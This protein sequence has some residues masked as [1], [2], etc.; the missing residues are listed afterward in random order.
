M[1]RVRRSRSLWV[2]VEVDSGIPVA[3]ESYSS[4]QAAEMRTEMLRD[5]MT[6]D[7]DEASAFE[8][9]LGRAPSPARRKRLMRR[10]G[11]RRWG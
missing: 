5:H 10:G 2:V 3:V 11:A 4:R 9:R 1:R 7:N 6:R 8:I